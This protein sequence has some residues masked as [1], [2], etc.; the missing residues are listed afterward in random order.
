MSVRKASLP[1]P[2][3][4]HWN[5]ISKRSSAYGVGDGSTLLRGNS[6]THRQGKIS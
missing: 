2:S 3:D 5:A 6:Q 4:A 1:L